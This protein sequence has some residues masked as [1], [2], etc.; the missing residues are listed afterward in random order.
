MVYSHCLRASA[1]VLSRTVKAISSLSTLQSSFLRYDLSYYINSNFLSPYVLL[2]YS[3]LSIQSC[4]ES[5]RLRCGLN[6]ETYVTRQCL[7][8]LVYIITMLQR[9]SALIS[10]SHALYAV[11]YCVLYIIG[12]LTMTTHAAL[13]ITS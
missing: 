8:F 10:E 4:S 9:L 3:S 6:C 11:L 1:V 5:H 2:K 13:Y 7:S 12:H